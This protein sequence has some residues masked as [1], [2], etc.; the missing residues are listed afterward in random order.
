M[1]VQEILKDG[2]IDAVET[3]EIRKEVYADGKVDREEVEALFALKDGATETCQEFK[4]LVV[5]A[6]MDCLTED[7]I[8]DEE[9]KMWIRELI[10]ADGEIDSVE[11]E[12]LNRING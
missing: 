1:N 5:E 8:I 11:R 2:V 6:T 3:A 7:G 9:E 10:E 12:I 4:D